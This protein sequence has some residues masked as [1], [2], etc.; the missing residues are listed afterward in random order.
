[1]ETEILALN[2]QIYK[3]YLFFNLAFLNDANNKKQ[4]SQR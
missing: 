4:E 1:M 2:K 3:Y